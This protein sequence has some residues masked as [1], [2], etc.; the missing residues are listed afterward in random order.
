MIYLLL[1]TIAAF[2]KAIADILASGNEVNIFKNLESTYF[3]P[4]K[5]SCKRKYKEDGKTPAFFLSTTLLVSFTDAWHKVNLIMILSLFSLLFL[6]AITGLEITVLV[7]LFFA[8]FEGFYRILKSE[9]GFKSSDLLVI[10]AFLFLLGAAG[11]NNTFFD[12]VLTW[13]IF[14]GT[15]GLSLLSAMI[16]GVIHLF[17]NE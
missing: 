7:C 15:G 12:E 8:S 2:A 13:Q 10:A 11:L 3:R 4:T 6:P 9:N 1:I 5:I 14:I 17:I 16:Y